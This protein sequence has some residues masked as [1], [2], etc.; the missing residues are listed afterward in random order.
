MEELEN[1]NSFGNY[2]ISGTASYQDESGKEN[3]KEVFCDIS[4]FPNSILKNGDFENLEDGSWT[5]ENADTTEIKWNDTPM[6]GEGALHFW[7]EGI[8]NFTM[9]QT[10]KAE[11]AGYYCASMYVQGEEKTENVLTISLENLTSKAL[12]AKDIPMKGWNVWQTETTDSVSAKA[13]DELLVLITVKGAAGAWGSID[14]V[15]LYKTN[16]AP[17]PSAEADK[18]TKTNACQKVKAAKKAYTIAKKGKTVKAVF[19]IT[20]KNN[21]KKTTD[22]VTAVTKN[23][24]IAKVENI[25]V[26]KGKVTVTV[27]GVKNGKTVLTVKIGKKSAKTEI[28]VK[29]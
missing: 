3:I 18:E 7:N 14:D 5:L 13:G 11:S 26:Q 1:I 16:K 29:K 21:E 10:V 4:V 20:A 24:K 15:F 27:K 6:R 19:R 22:K 9:K 23:K 28:R 25:L 12:A 2:T 8:V 17:K